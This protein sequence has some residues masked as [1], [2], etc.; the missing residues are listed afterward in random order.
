M[1]AIKE[2]KI[3]IVVPVLNEEG[4]VEVL[5][6]GI[7]KE[8]K[9][10]Y[11]YEIIFVDDGSVDGTLEAIKKARKTDKNIKYIS[12]S[13]NFGHQNALRAG[14]DFANG[15]CVISI[16]GDMQHPPK[17]IP[18]MLKKWEEG[19]DVVYTKRKDDP[20]TPYLKR[21]TSGCFYWLMNLFSDVKMD[22][23]VADYRLLDKEVAS[24]LRGMQENDLFLRGMMS[25][26][27]FKQYGMEYLP[28][29]RNWGKTKYSFRKMIH[30]AASGITSFSIRPLQISIYFGLFLALFSFIYGLYAI[31]VKLY[32]DTSVSGRTSVLTAIL[33]I[34]GVQMIMMGIL[35]E[36]IGKLFMESK[37]RPNYIIKERSGE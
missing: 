3:S 15:D 9:G 28:E 37:R 26:L 2:K 11:P 13:R 4:N 35:G 16:D 19:F 25:W 8:I 29:K 32:L 23:G 36:Y 27:G 17:L 22:K 18:E 7:S 10:R 33:F 21:K 5:I 12:F 20:G 6:G 14:L 1:R 34:G 31:Y 30:L 24:V